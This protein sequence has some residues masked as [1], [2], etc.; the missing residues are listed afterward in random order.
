MSTDDCATITW[1]INNYSYYWQKNNEAVVSPVFSIFVPEETKWKLMFFPRGVVSDPDCTAFFLYRDKD[2]Y[3]VKNIK[4]DFSLDYL[5]SDG[6]FCNVSKM[7]EFQKNVRRGSLCYSSQITNGSAYLQQDILTIRCRLF[8]FNDKAVERSKIFFRTIFGAK[9][10]HSQLLIRN[11]IYLSP[12]QMQSFVIRS[13]SKDVIME[14]NLAV[15][16]ENEK[17]LCFSINCI[18]Q[19]VK[20]F[21]LKTFVIDSQMQKID[22]GE[23]DYWS[24]SGTE[25]MF[26]LKFSK[27]YLIENKYRFLSNDVLTLSFEFTISTGLAFEGIEK[28]ASEYTSHPLSDKVAESWRKCIS[29]TNLNDC[30]CTLITDLTSLH[31]DQSTCDVKLETKTNTF[32]IH[33]LILSARSPVF[34][35]MFSN[36]MKEKTSGC[37][38]VSDLQDETVRRF[39]LYL[40]TDQLEDLTWDEALQLFKAADKYAVVSLREKCSVF[41]ERNLN[42]ENACEALMFSDLHQDKDL[43]ERTQNFILKNAKVIFKSEEW[44][45]LADNNSKLA[46]ETALRNWNEK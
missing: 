33:T 12:E 5:K 6:S 24:D 45:I 19:R 30:P 10:L 46:L 40:Y 27:K 20:Y 34:K 15:T 25:S 18:H 32:P 17:N 37:A 4:V 13:E 36:D 22:S 11:L 29:H 9:K 16:N 43:K 35:A 38:D 21:A 7:D 8:R 3:G 23:Y 39:L 31:K 44:K 2:C 1:A 41:L 42:L 28:T 26:P 14:I